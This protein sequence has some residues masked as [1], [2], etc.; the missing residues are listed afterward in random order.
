LDEVSQSGIKHQSLAFKPVEEN[1]IDWE[2][3]E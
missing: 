2:G 3:E 1:G